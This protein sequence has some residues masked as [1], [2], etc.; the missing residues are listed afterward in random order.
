MYVSL[1]MMPLIDLLLH[2]QNDKRF[3]APLQV[4]VFFAEKLQRASHFI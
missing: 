2:Q 1:K 4:K 3:Q